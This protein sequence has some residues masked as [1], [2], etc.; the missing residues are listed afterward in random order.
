VTFIGGRLTI[1]DES[2]V[3]QSYATDPATLYGAM[4]RTRKALWHVED[5]R[6]L[7]G[8]VFRFGAAELAER[9]EVSAASVAEAVE[10]LA[11]GGLVERWPDAPGGPVF[12]LSSY[13]AELLGLELDATG[14]RWRH[15]N[16]RKRADQIRRRAKVKSETD[17]GVDLDSFTEDDMIR[18]FIDERRPTILLGERLQWNGPASLRRPWLPWLGCWG[19][20]P[21]CFDRPPTASRTCLLC[22]DKPAR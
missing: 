5:L 12:L 13:A 2:P 21:G 8:R 16:A 20:C 18:A 4:A 11:A 1:M 3:Y 7:Y 6:L 19:Y 22:D 17:A 9:W 14:R 10:V 15:R